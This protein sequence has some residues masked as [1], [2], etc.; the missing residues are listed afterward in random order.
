M[1]NF[2]VFLLLV[3][4]SITSC[5]RVPD[6]VQSPS[7]KI[8]I[9]YRDGAEVYLVR[10]SAGITNENNSTALGAVKGAINIIDPEKNDRIISFPFSVDMVLPFSVGIIDAEKRCSKEEI[11]PVIKLF[12]I[13]TDEMVKNK[14]TDGIYIDENK[15][16]LAIDSYEKYDIVTLLEGKLNE[17]N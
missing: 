12:D 11:D 5:T 7:L 9:D 17:K 10:I 16:S 3:L 15:I 4:F 6:K 1:K 8:D 2:V 13:D 14:G